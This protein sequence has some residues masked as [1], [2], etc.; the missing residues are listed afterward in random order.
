MKFSEVRLSSSAA[1]RI[2]SSLRILDL[3]VAIT[4]DSAPV[5]V[6]NYGWGPSVYMATIGR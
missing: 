1:V 4:S 2:V 5:L 6:D 3:S